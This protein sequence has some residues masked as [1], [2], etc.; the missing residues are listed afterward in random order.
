M[1]R[2]HAFSF[3]TDKK[4]LYA[5][6]INMNNL[7]GGSLPL[8]NQG[9]KNGR[10]MRKISLFVLAVLLFAP[11]SINAAERNETEVTVEALSNDVTGSWSAINSGLT[12]T[13][14]YALAIDPTNPSIIY[15]GTNAGVFKSTDW[16][17][18]WSATNSGSTNTHVM[19]LAIDPSNAG[20]IYAGS[21][22][23]VLKS[24]DGGGRWSAM[25]SG[26][27]NTDVW[28][29]AIDPSNT[30]TLYAGTQRGV[31]KSADGGGHW[32]HLAT[33]NAVNALAIDPSNTSIIYAMIQDAGVYKSTDGGDS[34]FSTIH[35]QTWLP[36]YALAIDP[37]NTSTLYAGGVLAVY[38]S[39][40]GG[41]NWLPIFPTSYGL[42]LAID[43]TDSGILYAG[44]WGLGI[45]KS[46]D[47]GVTW[48]AIN[49]GLTS[50]AGLLVTA[51]AIDPTNASIMYAG[52]WGGV[53]KS[54]PPGSLSLNVFKSGTS[55][56]SVT[57]NPTGIDCGSTCAAS[58]DEGTVV[59]LTAT[60]SSGSIFAGWSGACSGT[61]DCV[62]TMDNN[63]SVTATFNVPGQL[64]VNILIVPE[65][66]IFGTV[67]VGQSS[68]QTITITNQAISTGTLIGSVGPL[69]APFSIVSGGE[70]FNLTAGQSMTVTVQ[71]SPTLVGAV[72]ESLSISH[73]AQN[74]PNPFNVPLSGTGVGTYSAILV[75]PT[76]QDYGNVKV[77]KSKTA[78]FKVT[79]TGK[80][81]LFILYSKVKGTDGSMFAIT[82]GRGS[83]HLKPGKSM[84]IK[85]AF[86]PVSTG[87]KSASLEITS[88][89]S[90]TP[91][92]NVPLS[93][94]G[95]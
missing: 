53:F 43:P 15:A 37:G 82:S 95:E 32:N 41:E 67:N 66:L 35:Y 14:V 1:G 47:G 85:V 25:N 20:T 34:W 26:L 18:N 11:M 48:N 27:T 30:S 7:L 28:A 90:V 40:D 3:A 87:S 74:Q 24:T 58:Y 10:V 57:S 13:Q 8:I 50:A 38:K 71:F 49:S 19:A 73:N 83:K 88:N 6:K 54:F 23:G 81:D 68:K 63:K 46:S 77:N 93:G 2:I 59:T 16:G 62:V 52:T 12:N 39:T 86:K 65:S 61:L 4:I 33:P 9:E 55:N 22:D 94:T 80:G 17:G 69:S 5:Y 60:P 75:S 29:L 91:T 76:A 64:G 45:F 79:N 44:T 42:A 70:P 21:N 36:G 92:V 78:S 56:G 72:S 84:T 31:F 51:L 89:D